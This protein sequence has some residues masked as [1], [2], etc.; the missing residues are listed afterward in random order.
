MGGA[1]LHNVGR[2]LK[3][4]LLF[5]VT[6]RAKP[7]PKLGDSQLYAH[8]VLCCD[9]FNLGNH[10]MSFVR[11]AL[12]ASALVAGIASAVLAQTAPAPTNPNTKVYAY[13]KTAPPQ[14]NTNPSAYAGA[15]QPDYRMPADAPLYGS[16]KWWEEKNRHGHGGGE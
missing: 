16:Q 10:S 14:G 12:A 5:S 7:V 15:T 3:L 4:P 13:K 11:I 2:R 6:V 8:A 1:L 9:D